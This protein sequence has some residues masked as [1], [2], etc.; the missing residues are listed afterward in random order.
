MTQ[1]SILFVPGARP[2]RFEKALAAGADGVCIDLE[3]AVAPADKANARRETIAFLANQRAGL[4]FRINALST[5]DG[6]RDVVAVAESGARPAF[7][8]IPKATGAQELLQLRAVLGEACPPLF[9]LMETADALYALPAM[10]RAVGMNGAIVFGGADYSAAIGSDMSWDALYSARAA[11]VAAAALSGCGA[12]DV[13]HLDVKDETGLQ[14]GTER[15]KALGFTG[16][17]CIHPDQVGVVNAVFTPT[18]AEIAKAE[19]IKAAY[20]AAGGG[21]ALLDGKLIE[22]P[23]LRAAERVLSRKG[24]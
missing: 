2:D 23:V 19:K 9:P 11:V 24:L 5:I 7:I 16:R 17:T 10:A 6:Y 15:A 1:R 3:D 12:L 4:G 8:M 20:A 21:V 14:T 13:P 22:A 18:T